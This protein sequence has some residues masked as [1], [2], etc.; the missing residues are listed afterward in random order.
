[1][2]FVLIFHMSVVYAPSQGS[3][4]EVLCSKTKFEKLSHRVV[5]WSIMVDMHGRHAGL[6]FGSSGGCR[7]GVG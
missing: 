4:N 2:N 5:F 7:L 3:G 6:G 1:M